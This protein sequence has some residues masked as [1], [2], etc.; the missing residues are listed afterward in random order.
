MGLITIKA[1]CLDDSIIGYRLYMKDNEIYDICVDDIEYFMD[2]A[3]EKHNIKYLFHSLNGYVS[4]G[5]YLTV[6]ERSG[7]IPTLEYA[8]IDRVIDSLGS[9]IEISTQSRV[10]ASYI[11]C[12]QKLL[13]LGIPLGDVF[14]VAVNSKLSRA[15]GRCRRRRTN[16]GLDYEIEISELLVLNGN[17][18]GL[19]TVMMHELLHTCEDCFKHTGTWKYYAEVVRRNLGYDIT[20][21]SSKEQLGISVEDLIKQG[22]YACQCTSCGAVVT[23]KSECKF[24]L[25]P[26]WYRCNCG[27]GFIRIN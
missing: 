20:T 25:H 23:K 26:E 7:D 17:K 15:Y 13:N 12:R 9:Y 19:D 2:K 3:I 16:I 24:I 5:E 4:N 11:V 18:V 22:Y 21:Y 6:G 1:L 10:Y 8:D 27:G 14:K